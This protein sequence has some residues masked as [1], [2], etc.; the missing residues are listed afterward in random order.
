[1]SHDPLAFLDWEPDRDDWGEV[2]AVAC[3]EQAQDQFTGGDLQAA[4]ATLDAGLE[5]VGHKD[6]PS[7]T[8]QAFLLATKALILVRGEQFDPAIPI[9]DRV[10]ELTDDSEQLLRLNLF[11]HALVSMLLAYRG[12]Y[13]PA[14]AAVTPY[15]TTYLHDDRLDIRAAGIEVYGRRL[16][17]LV[18][19]D[20]I[21]DAEREW[22][23][24]RT[25][26]A[27][28]ADPEIRAAVAS[29]GEG[30]VVALLERKKNRQVL[31][32]ADDILSLYRTEAHPKIRAHIAIVLW[33]RLIALRR[34]G[35]V[36]AFSRGL[37]DFVR[38]VGSDP[39]PEV[40]EAMKRY[41]RGEGLVR[42]IKIV[43]S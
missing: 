17:V 35:R 31:A 27:S 3:Y 33:V 30:Q 39:E 22:R 18:Y 29:A 4:L 15:A 5:T 7:T 41:P 42:N 21:D 19:S 2:D 1:V 13:E 38:F 20:R 11:G 10:T 8:E 40:V 16:S 25:D 23:D 43:N 28:D 24:L 12:E 6:D 9:L 26:H 37:R 36:L 34:R 32:M 14:L